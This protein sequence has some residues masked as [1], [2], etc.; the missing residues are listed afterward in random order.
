MKNVNERLAPPTFKTE[1]MDYREELKK[2]L[3]EA[4]YRLFNAP[5]GTLV[6]QKTKKNP[7]YYWSIWANRA[8][9]RLVA[10][11][12]VK[13]QEN[14]N[15]SVPPV[16]PEKPP[17]NQLEEENHKYKMKYIPRNNKELIV[18]LGQ[19]SYDIKL[20]KTLKKQI[21]QLSK[22]EEFDEQA[23]EKLTP[24]NNALR[25]ELLEP[26]TL[27]NEEYAKMW[28]KE[29]YQG[30]KMEEETPMFIT[31]NNELVRSKS[32]LMIANELKRCNIPY[33]YEYPVTLNEEQKFTVYPDFCCLNTRT[34]KEILWE[35]FGLVDDE[36]YANKMVKKISEYRKNNFKLGKNLILTMETKT[37]P[38]QTAEIKQNIQT[39]LR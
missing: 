32:E 36:E 37:T 19:K 6:I 20:V 13:T 38:L 16:P 28:A 39:F 25:K 23:I 30:K 12:G 11:G 10:A 5:P 4:E 1:V 33:K 22:M 31:D 18:A 26:I 15:G 2:C 35:H 17:L 14:G 34:R 29:E 21:K 24:E 3:Q 7:Q 8:N 27:S 9:N